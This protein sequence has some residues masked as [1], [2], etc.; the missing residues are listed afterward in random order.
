MIWV[1]VYYMTQY[2]G[3]DPGISYN[4]VPNRQRV[5][6]SMPDEKTCQQVAKLNYGAECWA[7]NKP[8]PVVST[9][10]MMNPDG[11]TTLTSPTF[12]GK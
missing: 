1:L 5:E 6:V 3:L 9:G 11:L 12:Q 7:H 2:A 8:E 4:Y 10:N